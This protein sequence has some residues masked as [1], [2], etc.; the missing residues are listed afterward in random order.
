MV[1][2]E[3]SEKI[4]KCRPKVLAFRQMKNTDFDQLNDLRRCT[5]ACTCGHAHVGDKFNNID[6]QNDHWYALFESIARNHTPLK[7]KRVPDKDVPYMTLTWKKA[8]TNKTKYAIQFA[9][10]RTPENL[11]LKRKYRNIARRERKNHFGLLNQRGL[12]SNPR[13]FFNT[14]RPFISSKTKDSNLICLQSKGDRVE[15]QIEVA[16][17]LAN[18]FPAAAK[19]IAEDHVTSIRKERLTIS[20]NAKREAMS[21]KEQSSSLTVFSRTKCKGAGN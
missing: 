7:R 6:D 17:Q 18:Y 11:E 8:I 3:M 21:T 20:V 5:V 1:Y 12:K 10:N 13:E 16:E 19:S 2:G 14:L 4:R 15:G 9:N